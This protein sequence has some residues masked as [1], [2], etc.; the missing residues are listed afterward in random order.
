V[1]SRTERDIAHLAD[2][3]LVDLAA[4]HQHSGVTLAALSHLNGYI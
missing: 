1:T 3:L 4:G 2:A